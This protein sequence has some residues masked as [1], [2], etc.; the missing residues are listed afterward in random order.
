MTALILNTHSTNEF[1]KEYSKEYI[2]ESS[3]DLSY[4]NAYYSSQI[5]ARILREISNSL[6]E[7]P[8]ED[9]YLHPLEN[10]FC[11]HIQDSGYVA[12]SCIQDIFTEKLSLDPSM[13]ADILVLM[14]RIKYQIMGL[15]GILMSYVA[16]TQTSSRLREAA[17]KLIENW[18]PSLA[19]VQ[20]NLE[21]YIQ[22]EEKAWLREYALEILKSLPKRSKKC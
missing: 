16:L 13:A 10:L 5:K 7:Y 11:N 17:L 14:G 1:I 15:P 2:N 21:N 19:L 18:N 4:I 8:V 6:N 9:G 20:S 12:I 3:N 22:R